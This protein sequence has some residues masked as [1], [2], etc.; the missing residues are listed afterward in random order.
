MNAWSR[1]TGLGD[2]PFKDSLRQR[3]N[4]ASQKILLGKEQEDPSL[5]REGLQIVRDVNQAI[6]DEEEETAS[7]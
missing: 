5:V 3:L 7:E 4:N 2:G 1:V 6:T